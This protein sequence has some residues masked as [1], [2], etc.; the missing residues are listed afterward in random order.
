MKFVNRTFTTKSKKLKT[1]IESN[2]KIVC[3]IFEIMFR[4][5]VLPVSMITGFYRF[6]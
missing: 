5:I 1:P 4:V 2:E 3:N 6:T